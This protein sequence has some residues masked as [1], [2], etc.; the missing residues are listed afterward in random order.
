MSDCVIC[1]IVTKRIP[2]WIVYQDEDVICFLPK[3]LDAYG[4]TI[5][6]P[7]NHFQDIYSVPDDILEVIFVTVKRIAGHYITQIGAMG[8][9]ILHASGE[10]AQQS[11]PHIHFHLL[12]RFE[13]DGLNAWPKFPPMEYNKDELL[14][15]IKLND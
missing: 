7:K 15:K 5:I 3:A 1:D 12:P 13:N 4:H 11:V 10:A 14:E 2:S 6:A 9:N 8:I